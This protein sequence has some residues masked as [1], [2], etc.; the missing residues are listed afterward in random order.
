[1]AVRSF[2]VPSPR[3]GELL[4]RIDRAAV[5]GSDL[6]AIFDG[7]GTLV[8]NPATPT[9]GEPGHEAVGLVE[10]SKSRHFTQGDHVL[11]LAVGAFAEYMAVPADMCLKLPA[12]E[13][14]DMMLMAQQL[15]VTLYAMERFWP[16]DT[17][18]GGTAVVI[19]VGPVGLHFLSLLK[20]AGFDTIVAADLLPGRL[21]LAGTL[22]ADVLVKT[23]EHSVVERAMELTGGAGADL[24]IEAA[25]SDQARADAIHCVKRYGRVGYFGYPESRGPA[26]FPFAE[27]FDKAPISIEVVKG[28]QL[29]PGLPHFREAVELISTARIPVSHLL[30]AEYPL[31]EISAALAAARQGAVLKAQLRPAHPTRSDAISGCA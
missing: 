16:A 24:V 15:G 5:C 8:G 21:E 10:E 28:A 6:H 17:S 2:P 29:V 11:I 13:P 4:V 26:P 18:P 20:L 12:G 25:G 22:G 31:A 1:M 30:G 14:M 7:L 23:P 9:P 3:D 19:G 27:A